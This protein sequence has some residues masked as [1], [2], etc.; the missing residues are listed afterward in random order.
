MTQYARGVAAFYV[1]TRGARF[2][3]PSREHSVLSAISAD[4]HKIRCTMRNRRWAGKARVLTACVTF[5]AERLLIMT[6]EAIRLFRA[7]IKAMREEIIQSMHVLLHCRILARGRGA[8][9]RHGTRHIASGEL[10]S[11]FGVTGLAE[12]F[13]M[14]N[15]AIIRA[16][17]GAHETLVLFRPIGRAMRDRE[18]GL[19]ARMARFARVRGFHVV[20]ARVAR[21]HIRQ[22]CET[23]LLG[24][25]DAGV[26]RR[27]FDLLIFDMLLVAE[28]KVFACGRGKCRGI[29]AV[30]VAILAVF[31]VL[32]FD[33][34]MASRA[35]RVFG[36]KKVAGFLARWR[37]AVTRAALRAE[38]FHVF[39]V[40]E[41]NVLPLRDGIIP[42]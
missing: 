20:V 3:I 13:G 31:D 9:F 7:Q 38:F 12:I 16:V 22:K 15:R 8:A 19:D 32:A 11:G 39:F 24:F 2:D 17:F 10:R 18:H 35:L 21:S 23:R 4:A 6:R 28:A 30:H 25:L 34:L 36:K 29:V 27:A 14:A 40:G 37:A 1:M 41:F 42:C 33:L 26:A 5:R